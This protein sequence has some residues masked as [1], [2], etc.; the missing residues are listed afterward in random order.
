MYE[1]S[2][3]ELA[4]TALLLSV[5][6]AAFVAVNLAMGKHE[7]SEDICIEARAK[8][9]ELETCQGVIE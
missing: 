1:S 3:E 9:F 5:I 7:Q 6:F 8:Q 2:E 4:K